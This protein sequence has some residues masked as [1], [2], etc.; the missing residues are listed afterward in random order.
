MKM[1]RTL[2]WRHASSCSALTLVRPRSYP[3]HS[4][5]ASADSAY[6]GAPVQLSQFLC[7][8]HHRTQYSTSAA[9][10]TGDVRVQFQR[11]QRRNLDSQTSLQ[12]KNLRLTSGACR[13]FP[14]SKRLPETQEITLPFTRFELHWACWPPETS[15]QS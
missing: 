1:K 6:E 9:S 8:L 12:L 13:R 10:A 7:K 2:G 15:F 5:E 4:I 11:I 3:S 14:L